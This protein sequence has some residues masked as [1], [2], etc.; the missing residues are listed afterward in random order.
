MVVDVRKIAQAG[1]TQKE[2]DHKT[3]L[4]HIDMERR[5]IS[6]APSINGYNGRRCRGSMGQGQRRRTWQPAGK[7]D[8]ANPHRAGERHHA[9]GHPSHRPAVD[10]KGQEGRRR[11]SKDDFGAYPRPGGEALDV[12]IRLT[13]LENQLSQIRTEMR[14]PMTQRPSSSTTRSEG[15]SAQPR[16]RRISRTASSSIPWTSAIPSLLNSE[17]AFGPRGHGSGGYSPGDRR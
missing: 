9:R 11:R 3:D 4:D 14:F 1:R 12:E 13:D 16:R 6:T 10:R 5:R 17:Q 15:E 8:S 2:D 7:A